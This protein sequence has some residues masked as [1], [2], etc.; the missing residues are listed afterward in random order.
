M[1][2]TSLSW[3]HRRLFRG[4]GRDHVCL[5]KSCSGLYLPHLSIF[6]NLILTD[7]LCI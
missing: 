2:L 7:G 5:G 6:S 4:K 1:F 3:L